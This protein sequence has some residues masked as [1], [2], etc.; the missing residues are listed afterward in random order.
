MGG[1]DRFV[2]TGGIG[3]NAAPMRRMIVHRLLWLGA[4]LDEAANTSN[5]TRISNSKS[6]IVFE[7]RNT[8]EELAIAAHVRDLIL[9]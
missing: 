9:Q 7:W 2:F 8:D 5:R 6:P 1:L 3:E 4:T